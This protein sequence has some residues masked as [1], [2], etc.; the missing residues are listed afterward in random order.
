MSDIQLPKPGQC[1]KHYK[2]ES[3]LYTIVGLGYHSETFEAVVVYR[4]CRREGPLWVR[5]L[6]NFLGMTDQ[7]VQRFVYF[8]E[9]E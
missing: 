3:P 6:S 2:P 9:E 7:Y 5:P 4:Q 1:W 8:R